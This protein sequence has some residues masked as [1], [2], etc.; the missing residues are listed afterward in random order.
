MWKSKLNEIKKDIVWIPIKLNVLTADHVNLF[1]LTYFLSNLFSLKTWYLSTSRYRI[2]QFYANV[3]IFWLYFCIILCTVWISRIARQFCWHE[4]LD[5]TGTV[6]L[7]SDYLRGI[8]TSKYLVQF[9]DFI[10]TVFTLVLLIENIWFYEPERCNVLQKPW[11]VLYIL[12]L[13][14]KWIFRDYNE[15]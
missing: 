7:A 12:I 15:Y 4:T 6:F 5:Q 9:S 14:M 8:C 2:T 10:R 11:M 3:V 1:L 13:L